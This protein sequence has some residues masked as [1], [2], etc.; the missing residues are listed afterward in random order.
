EQPHPSR[1]GRRT[2]APAGAARAAAFSFPPSGRLASMA[3]HDDFAFLLGGQR[4]VAARGAA[5]N[6]PT[7]PLA[8]L[9]ERVRRF[10]ETAQPGPQML[11]GAVPYER[12]RPHWLIQPRELID[13]PRL[14]AKAYAGGPGLSVIA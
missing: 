3:D 12:D 8:S 5:A 11:L 1:S 6:L 13:P 10:F 14:S 7:G 4:P 2:D 9:A